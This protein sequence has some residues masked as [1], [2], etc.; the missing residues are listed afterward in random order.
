MTMMSAAHPDPE[1]LAALAGQDADAVSDRALTEHVHACAECA[2]QVREL[3]TLRAALAELPDLI[4]SRPMQ[5]VPPV[6]DLPVASG[7]RT[8]FRRAFAPVAVAGMV[9][10]L[11]GGVGATGALGPADAQRMFF[12]PFQAATGG[13]PAEQPITGEAAPGVTSTDGE[14]LVPAASIPADNAGSGSGE[15]D[16][17]TSRGEEEPGTP[18]AE[19]DLDAG[20]SVSGWLILAVAGLALLILAF[21]LRIAAPTRSP[22]GR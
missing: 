14:G 8:V 12:M 7:W 19:H 16:P 4:P 18:A 3:S 2:T 21:V 9:L 11:V 13:E 22:A 15:D 10:L 1:R 20:T 6:A 5:L 17:G